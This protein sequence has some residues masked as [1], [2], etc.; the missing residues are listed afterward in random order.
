MVDAAKFK[1]EVDE[2][3][4]ERVRKDLIETKQRLEHEK[5]IRGRLQGRKK[6]LLE[7]LVGQDFEKKKP[8][9]RIIASD[10]NRKFFSVYSTIRQ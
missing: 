3:R 10:V 1:Q 9:I 2:I 7:S 8:A 5:K 4:K 6:K